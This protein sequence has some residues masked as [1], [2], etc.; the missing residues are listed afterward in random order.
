[1]QTKQIFKVS[2]ATLFLGVLAGCQAVQEDTQ[3][4]VTPVGQSTSTVQIVNKTDFGEAKTQEKLIKPFDGSLPQA[5]IDAFE[6]AD[7]AKNPQLCDAIATEAYRKFC[8]Q[9]AGDKNAPTLP[10]QAVTPTQENCKSTSDDQTTGTK[11]CV[12]FEE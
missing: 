7:A 6:K 8:K 9:Q 1:M 11:N 10:L 5:D 4:P 2:M 3:V 12:N